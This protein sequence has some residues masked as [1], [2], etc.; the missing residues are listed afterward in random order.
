MVTK[1]D[2]YMGRYDG[3]QFFEDEDAEW[4]ILVTGTPDEG[5]SVGLITFGEVQGAWYSKSLSGAETIAEEN[6]REQRILGEEYRKETNG[7][8]YT[9]VKKDT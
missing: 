7:Q 9:Y 3:E 2:K 6:R 5:Y 8:A 1:N 4:I